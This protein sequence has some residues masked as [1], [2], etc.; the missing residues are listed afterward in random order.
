MHDRIKRPQ[1][2]IGEII[3]HRESTPEGTVYTLIY[4]KSRDEVHILKYCVDRDEDAIV[5]EIYKRAKDDGYKLDWLD[6]AK[7]SLYITRNAVREWT[8]QGY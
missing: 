5:D 1:I 3:S 2:R 4:V 8:V 7:L 6:A